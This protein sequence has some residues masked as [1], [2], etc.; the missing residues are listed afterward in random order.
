MMDTPSPVLTKEAL[1]AALAEGAT[2]LTPNNRLSHQL[3]EDYFSQMNAS[4]NSKPRCLPYQAFLQDRYKKARHLYANQTHPLLLTSAQQHHLWWQILSSHSNYTY[5]DGLQQEI[6]EAW[7]HCQQWNIH[8][9]HPAFQQTPQT[10]Q[11]QRWW[12]QFEKKLIEINAITTEQLTPHLLN[13]P[14]LFTSTP[15]VWACFDDFTP[16]Q[17]LLQQGMDEQGSPQFIYD[18]EQKPNTSLLFAANDDEEE[19][20]QMIGWL[21]QKL[22]AQESRIG[23]VIPDLKTQSHRVKRFLHRYIPAHQFNISLG[24]SLA[25]FSMVAHALVWLNLDSYLLTHHQA[26]LLLHS[27][28]LAGSKSEFIARSDI[29]QNTRVLQEPRLSFHGWIDSLKNNT[30]I[31]ADCLMNLTEYPKEAPISTWAHLFKAR[32]THLG[33]P[34]EYPLDS[35]TYQCFQ[36]FV[37]LFDEYLQLSVITPI[38]KKEEA[39]QAFMTLAKSTIFQSKTTKT[40][41]QL[42]GLLEASG[43]TF[44]S[45]WICGLTNQ[46]LPQKNRLSAFIPLELQRSL[47]MPHALPQRELQFAEQSLKRLRRGSQNSVF[48]YSRLT[49]DSPNLPSPL[50]VDLPPFVP[51]ENT[52]P[53]HSSKLMRHHEDYQLPFMQNESI[54]GGTSLLANQA[55]CP[56]RAFAMHR[57]YAIAAPSLSDGPDASERGQLLHKIMELLWKAIGSQTQLLSLNESQLNQQVDAVIR[58]AMIPLAQENSQSFSSLVQEVEILRLT[59]LVHACLNWEKQRPPFIVEALEQEF[60]I[61]LAGIDFRVRIDRLDKTSEGSKWVIDYK[62]SLPP[63]KPWSE[64]RPEAPQL[65]LYSLLDDEINTLLFIQLKSGQVVC[66]GIS[67]DEI[68]LDGISRLKKDDTWTEKQHQWR[69]QLTCLAQEIQDGYCPPIPT[70]ESTCQHCDVLYLCRKVTGINN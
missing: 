64:E 26:C 37:L 30:P 67:D 40:P 31:L 29:M 34:G 4:V 17:R 5:N 25:D 59:R 24:Q 68:Q 12:C 46:C 27:P 54:S 58:V 32:L 38:L 19:W 66:S 22:A 44:D 51:L 61:P 70:K 43:C 65:L 15:V 47:K 63:T 57:L 8:H 41:I 42:L 7:T 50:I 14:D 35:V 16:Q 62:S 20:L 10:Q 11:F 49:G 9:Q 60:V 23:I 45:V 33:F 53:L 18:L 2:V 48:S 3:L 56:F 28:Y 1:F 36:R 13:Y 69:Q 39:L 21:Q 6:E 52:S 55:K